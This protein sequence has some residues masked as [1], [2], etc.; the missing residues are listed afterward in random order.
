MP[1]SE[2]SS[3]SVTLRLV[4]VGKAPIPVKTWTCRGPGARRAPGRRA[5]APGPEGPAVAEPLQPPPGRLRVPA[6]GSVLVLTRGSRSPAARAA[7]GGNF[8]DSGSDSGLN[9][10][11]RARWVVCP[12]GRTRG[13]GRRFI[14]PRRVREEK[15]RKKI[16]CR[17][18]V[19]LARTQFKLTTQA[20]YCPSEVVGIIASRDL[21]PDRDRDRDRDAGPSR[22]RPPSL[23]RGRWGRARR[24]LAGGSLAA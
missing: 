9:I 3:F 17:L 6:A 23:R 21:N 14:Y 10:S 4:F 1:A 12:L 8:S 19:V 5:R 13:H 20:G 11:P 24:Q 2:F 7:G 22:H 18:Q 15:E 16:P